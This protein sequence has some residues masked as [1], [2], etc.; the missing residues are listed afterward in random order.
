TLPPHY[1]HIRI[2]Q[3]AY[4]PDQNNAFDDNLL[5]RSV[6]LVITQGGAIS[7]HVHDVAPNTPQLLY[8]NIS[9]LYKSLL[10]DWLA[11]ADQNGFGREDAFYHVK[12][13][14]PFS[15]NSPSS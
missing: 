15:G 7:Q 8:T 6:D 1:G 12:P 2:A 9:T 14:T 3:L 5:A 11:F 10:T 13:A 4:S